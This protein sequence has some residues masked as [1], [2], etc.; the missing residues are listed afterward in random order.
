MQQSII[1]K[2]KVKGFNIMPLL[3]KSKKPIL[4]E[5]T[6][7][8]TTQYNGNFPEN[9]NVAV[10]C[11]T[12]SGNLFVI[13][14]DDESLYNEFAEYHGKTYIVRTGKRGYHIYFR[15]SGGFPIENRKLDDSRGR[16]IDIQSEGKYVLSEGCIHPDTGKT[17][18]IVHDLPVMIIDFE[19]LKNKIKG[20]GFSLEKLTYEDIEKGISAGGRN[21]ATFKYACHLIRDKGLY[22]E[23]LKKALDDLNVRHTPPLPRQELNIIIASAM[24]YEKHS[25]KPHKKFASIEEFRDITIEYFSK[26]PVKEVNIKEVF[27]EYME[28]IGEDMIKKVITEYIDENMKFTC[29]KRVRI[30]DITPEYEGKPVQFDGMV[31]AVGER[32]TYTKETDVM[33][34]ECNTIQRIKCNEYHLL[35]LPKC[36]K[37]QVYFKVVHSSK[38]TG[39]IQQLRI[40]EFME[41]AFN[42]SPLEIDAEI[43]E[44]DVGEVFY[45]DRKTFTAKMRS[46]TP[47]KVSEDYN[48]I[49][50]EVLEMKDFE[51]SANCMPTPEEIEKW[52]ANPKIFEYV[53]DSIA[54]E[55]YMVHLNEMKESGMLAVAGG[56]SLNGKRDNINVAW[57]G[58][59]Q[60]G[61]SEALK[62]MLELVAGSGY[63]VGGR[64][65]GAGLTIGMVK[66][67][68]ST[69]IPQAGFFPRH[70]GKPVGFDEADKAKKEDIQSIYECM[71][72]GTC[73]VTLA[74]TNGGI[75]LPAS[76]PVIMCANPKGGKY[77]ADLPRLLDNFDFPEPFIT[78]FDLLFLL[79]DKNDP[80]LDDLVRNHIKNFDKIKYMPKDELKRYFTFV[81][82]LKAKI[83]KHLEH[84]IDEL[85]KKMRPY[86]IKGITPIGIRQYYGLYRLLTACAVCNLREEVNESD[87]V[88]I[89][90]MVFKSLLSF[91]IDLKTGKVEDKFHRKKDSRT[92][93]MLNTWVDLEDEDHFV[94]KK[95]FLNAIAGNELTS[96]NPLMWFDQ[97]ERTGIIQLDN[98]TGLYKLVRKDG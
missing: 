87:F 54:P 18:E 44:S 72:Q 9:C 6:S 5:W 10:I 77:N 86:N 59:G 31:I 3:E 78:R 25:I 51:Q 28:S 26:N 74:G 71:E 14:L 63:A 80:T 29:A 97:L 47:Q 17:Y 75:T 2:L 95:D 11:G 92:T 8:K 15:T 93:Y 1:E 13:D 82:T 20:M 33:C 84:K 30:R 60:L 40:Q 37:D 41:D 70:H 98:E 64:V 22:D 49:V 58:D 85:H 83:P 19:T 42:N 21:D 36:K 66:M 53:R 73:T 57:V 34:S 90:N 68:N 46:I 35:S 27:P 67:Y 96:L 69:S 76:C 38:I 52:R 7:L 48:E 23:A 45:G 39:Y 43:M 56:I 16:H 81:R 4:S 91:G 12:L 79:V 61:K 88:R 62:A 24:K 55:Q 89:E 32:K 94:D 65:S 50:Y